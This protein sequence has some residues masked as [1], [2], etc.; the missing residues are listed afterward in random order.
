ME[1]AEQLHTEL[2]GAIGRQIRHV[3]ENS[4]EFKSL[5]KN[6][7]KLFI[8]FFNQLVQETDYLLP[9]LKEADKSEEQ[10]KNTIEKFSDFKQVFIAK[11]DNKIVGFIGITRAKLQKIKHIA[12]FAIGVLA[13]SKR[14]GIATNLLNIAERWLSERNV[15]RLE[16]TVIAENN[17]AISFYQ[18]NGFQQEGIRKNSI[19]MHNRYYNEVYMVKFI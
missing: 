7:A 8:D 19:F 13:E 17:A 10:E 6:E 9:T 3:G 11:E 5:E 18:K 14:N 15:S 12:N 4:M 2:P 1:D 16:M